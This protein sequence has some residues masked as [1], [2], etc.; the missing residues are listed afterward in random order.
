[1]ERALQHD[2]RHKHCNDKIVHEPV[3]LTFHGR[4]TAGGVSWWLWTHHRRPQKCLTKC[5]A[6][7]QP[8]RLHL[9]SKIPIL[10]H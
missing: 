5:N 9:L 7:M 6:R 4:V 10:N 3:G 8:S 1:M 2:T